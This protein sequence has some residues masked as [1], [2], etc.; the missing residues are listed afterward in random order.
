MVANANEPIPRPTNASVRPTGHR[1]PRRRS[2]STPQAYRPTAQTVTTNGIGSMP[3][4]VTTRPRVN[5]GRASA[6][7]TEASERA[8]S[9]L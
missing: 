2:T 5:L 8:V 6:A 9:T 4:S 3:Q 7:A 1:S